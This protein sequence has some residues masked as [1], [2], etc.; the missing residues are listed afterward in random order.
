MQ[1]T[2]QACLNLIFLYLLTLQRMSKIIGL[3]QDLYSDQISVSLSEPKRSIKV[4]HTLTRQ[5]NSSL[6][7]RFIYLMSL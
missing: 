6:Y 2:A 1:N 3:A 4:K 7:F 5:K